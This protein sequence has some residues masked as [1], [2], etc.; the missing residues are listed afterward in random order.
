VLVNLASIFVS[1]LP[2]RYRARLGGDFVSTQGAAVSGVIQLIVCLGMLGYRYVLYANQRLFAVPDKVVLGAAEQGGETAVMGM[3]LFILVEYIFQPITL[4]I[5]YFAFEGFIRGTAALVTGE[6]VPTLPLQVAAWLHGRGED[7]YHEHQ[8]GPRVVDEVKPGVAG[9]YDLVI[10]SC[11]PKPWNKSHTVRYNDELYELMHEIIG[12]PPRR[13]V[14]VLRKMPPGKLVRGLYD[15]EPEE[16][17]QKS[18]AD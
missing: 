2:R 12:E 8:L 5:I 4:V 16:T 1:L 15:Y 9:D 18:A 13:F 11:R 17:L 7:H 10:E 14:Y 3:G 6:I